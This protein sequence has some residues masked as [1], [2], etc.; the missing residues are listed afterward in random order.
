M[1]KH[2]SAFGDDAV[3]I[4]PVVT[5]SWDVSPA[6]AMEIQQE[7]R[8]RLIVE[9]LQCNPETVGGVDVSVKAG[10]AR[11]AVVVLSWPDLELRESATAELPVSFPYVPGLLAFREGP[12]V[13]EALA[14]LSRA[15]DVLVFD[16][17][18]FAHPRRIGLAT[19]LGIVLDLPT[20]G[21]AKSRLSGEH[22]E[23][24]SQRG[25]WTDLRDGDEVIGAV[26]RTR[27]EVRPVFVSVGHRVDLADAVSLVLESAP[28][29]RLPE[30]IRWAHRVAG[31]EMLHTISNR[32][33]PQP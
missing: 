19:H 6:Q 7:L 1:G 32:E 30:P 27:D 20:V 15:P 29:Y 9:P 25:C 21:C 22:S 4:K 12:V 16:A 17:H 31:G 8:S 10:R 11:G 13:L 33:N 5:H 14:R 24:D 18:G 23:P 2:P 26:L 3:T 28:R